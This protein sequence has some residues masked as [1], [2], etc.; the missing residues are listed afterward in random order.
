MGLGVFSQW[1]HH[2][3]SDVKSGILGPSLLDVSTSCC[4]WTGSRA[5]LKTGWPVPS[6]RPRPV[7]N[8]SL[9]PGPGNVSA[10]RTEH[11]VAG[12]KSERWQKPEEPGRRQVDF[13]WCLSSQVALCQNQLTFLA[14]N[15]R[16]KVKHLHW[17]QN[18]RQSPLLWLMNWAGSWWSWWS[19]TMPPPLCISSAQ[20]GH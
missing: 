11:G 15:P 18:T 10:F 17:S 5:E 16:L 7:K 8:V 3:P 4:F 14:G 9:P 1:K 12:F 2:N 19:I 6:L 13:W 20:L